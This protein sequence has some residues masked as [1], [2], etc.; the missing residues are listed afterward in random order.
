MVNPMFKR[1]VAK[2]YVTLASIHLSVGIAQLFSAV[3]LS[4]VLNYE[5]KEN[6]I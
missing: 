5:R 2:K 3:Q 6:C 4:T 1:F